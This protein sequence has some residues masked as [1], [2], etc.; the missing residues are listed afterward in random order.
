MSEPT[1]RVTLEHHPENV[2]LVWTASVTRLSDD[3]VIVRGSNCGALTRD[4]AFDLAVE[5]IRT[6]NLKQPSREIFLSEREDIL[7]PHEAQR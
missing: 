7:D 1:Y 6:Y 2:S 5:A 3:R 4:D